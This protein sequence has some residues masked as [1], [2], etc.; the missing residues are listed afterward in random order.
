MSGNYQQQ[1]HQSEHQQQQSQHQLHQYE[2]RQK[3]PAPSFPPILNQQS[4]PQ[5]QQYY[6]YEYSTQ[7]SPQQQQQQSIVSYQLPP[8]QPLQPL[9]PARSIVQSY[10]QGLPPPPPPPQTQPQ[11]YT[12]TIPAQQNQPTNQSSL[13]SLLNTSPIGAIAP[14]PILQKHSSQNLE[15]INPTSGSTSS[16]QPLPQI[17]HSQSNIPSL[18]YEQTSLNQQQTHQQTSIP[19]VTFTHPYSHVKDVLLNSNSDQ[20]FNSPLPPVLPSM[21]KQDNSNSRVNSIQSLLQT[22]DG[23]LESINAE[24]KIT[25]SSVQTLPPPKKFHS[26][27]LLSLMN[28]SPEP[29]PPINTIPTDLQPPQL[30]SFQ[31]SQKIVV[32]EDKKSK[33]TVNKGQSFKNGLITFKSAIVGHTFKPGFKPDANLNK[34]IMKHELSQFQVNL[35]DGS[36]SR[37]DN[38]LN[39][40]AYENSISLCDR[41]S[42]IEDKDSGIVTN[43]TINTGTNK[44]EIKKLQ[45]KKKSANPAEDSVSSSPSSSSLASMSSSTSENK[46]NLNNGVK[47]KKN[48]IFYSVEDS[49]PHK[50]KKKIS[51]KNNKM[52]SQNESMSRFKIIQSKPVESQMV[53]MPYGPPKTSRFF[54]AAHIK[55]EPIDLNSAVNSALNENGTATPNAATGSST[56]SASTNPS[57]SNAHHY[58]PYLYAQNRNKANAPFDVLLSVTHQNWDSLRE[59]IKSNHINDPEFLS[60]ESD[61]DFES[62]PILRPSITEFQDPTSYIESKTIVKLISERTRSKN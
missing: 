28:P 49:F 5:Q 57:S 39:G 44:F 34:S 33:K 53:K 48:L 21:L 42:T 61:N 31:H 62:I 40:K 2:A 43:D 22:T 52:L 25:P 15:P 45:I 55:A 41:E 6:Q 30:H 51:S 38:K 14:S 18:L 3:L 60:S 7:Q 27:N 35:N 32:D 12:S 56:S 23:T 54:R 26:S 13:Q 24:A 47:S 4:H 58:N 16:Q 46:G 19:K 50:K 36:N 17:S 20:K 9:Q 10:Q 8:L 29:S 59:Q 11:P 37:L 1:Q